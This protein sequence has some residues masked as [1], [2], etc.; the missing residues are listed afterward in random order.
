MESEGQKNIAMFIDCDNVSAKYIESIF[1]D[2]SQYGKVNIKKAYGDWKDKKLIGWE[3]ILQEYNIQPFQQ[4][5]YTQNKNATDI[6]IVIDAMD[7]IYTKKI[8][9]IALITS[10]SD[11]T[12]LVTRILSDGITVY[13]YGEKKTPI[14]LVNACTQFIF[15][16]RFL[17]LK[18]NEIKNSKET[19]EKFERSLNFNNNYEGEFYD[20]KRNHT[21][22]KSFIQVVDMVSNSSG[23]ADL[24][25][26]GLYIRQN[27]SFSPVNHGFKKLG[28]LMKHLEIFDVKYTNN[29]LTMLVRIKDYD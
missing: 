16:E 15:V 11:F 27:S 12:P 5:P 26:V 3:K 10:D 29:N 13:G 21:L 23:W 18:Q 24:K 28:D 9:G 1:E 22:K 17:D 6:A 8:D 20:A 14:A 25:D 19:K 2:L 4:F 7:A